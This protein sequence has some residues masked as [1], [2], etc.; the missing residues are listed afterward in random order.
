VRSL[1][2]ENARG[3]DRFPPIRGTRQYVFTLDKIERAR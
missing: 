3:G 2:E 1:A